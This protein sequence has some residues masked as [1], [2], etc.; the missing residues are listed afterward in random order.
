MKH[1]KH[2][3]SINNPKIGDY[4]VCYEE[5]EIT[6]SIKDIPGFK[7]FLSNNVGRYINV[8]DSDVFP[9]EIQY[10]NIPIH[11]QEYYFNDDGTRQFSRKQI[12]FHS[13]D[14]EKAKLFIQAIKYNL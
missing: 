10:E 2:F 4:V 11:L 12:L 13:K 9:Y 14:K 1:I 7:N 6:K 3:E 5:D 8:F